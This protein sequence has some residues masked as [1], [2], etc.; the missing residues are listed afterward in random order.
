MCVHVCKYCVE[1]TIKVRARAIAVVGGVG[2]M[3]A[4]IP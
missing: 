2:T 3:E 4:L 1:L